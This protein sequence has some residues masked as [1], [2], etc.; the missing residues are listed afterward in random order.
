MVL[1]HDPDIPA[2]RCVNWPRSGAGVL[3]LVPAKR[4]TT[5]IPGAPATSAPP[6]SQP[7]PEVCST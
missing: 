4:S 1:N 7:K 6:S 3:A 5:A 2:Q